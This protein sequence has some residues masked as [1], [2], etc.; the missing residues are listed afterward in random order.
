MG[1]KSILDFIE[2]VLTKLV[3][4]LLATMTLVITYQVVLRYIFHS[5][6]IWAEE[7]ARYAFVWV[8]MMGS[9]I[10][11]RKMKHIRIDFLIERMS[12]KVRKGFDLFSL[13][14][15]A[16]FLVCLMVYGVKIF[17]QT[18]NQISAGLHI[19]ISYI[20]VSIPISCFLMLLFIIENIYSDHFMSSN[21]DSL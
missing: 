13:I 7:F 11:M 18:G 14:M 16:T 20:Y 17:M 9:V 15:M 4:I 10:A 12:P 1:F 2:N 6:N 5:S 8:V 21:E 19:P 3:C